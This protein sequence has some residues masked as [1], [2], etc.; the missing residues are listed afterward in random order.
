M[1]F[2]LSSQPKVPLF[3][4]SD[5]ISLKTYRACIDFLDPAMLQTKKW[6]YSHD[7]PLTTDKL[8]NE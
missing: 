4:A 3:V 7:V 8:L 2:V 6:M 1:L 5:T